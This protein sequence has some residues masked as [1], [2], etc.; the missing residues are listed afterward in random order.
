M[1]ACGLHMRAGSVRAARVARDLY[2]F[3]RVGPV[4]VL[5]ILYLNRLI[6]SNKLYGFEPVRFRQNKIKFSYEPIPNGRFK[7]VQLAC[8]ITSFTLSYNFGLLRSS[9][10]LL[11]LHAYNSVFNLNLHDCLS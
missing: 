8:S 2:G 10:S 5:D 6:F 3:V 9:C 4:P 11:I 1:R 7:T